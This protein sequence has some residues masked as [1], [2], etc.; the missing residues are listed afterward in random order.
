MYSLQGVDVNLDER[1]ERQKS[2]D[3]P[4]I[5]TNRN[6]NWLANN[7]VRKAAAAITTLLISQETHC[8]A[9]SQLN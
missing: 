3:T 8:Y 6:V 7:N 9:L 4:F 5:I 2:M 1:K